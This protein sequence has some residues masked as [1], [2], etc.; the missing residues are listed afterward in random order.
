[1]AT[2]AHRI[3]SGDDSEIHDEPHVEGKR[4]TARFIH[5]RVEEYGLDPGIVA[6]RHDLDVADVYRVLAYFHDN[7]GKMA[8]VERQRRETIQRHEGEMVGPGDV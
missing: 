3:V 2:T 6:D 5:N 1:M 4:I 7:P 8:D